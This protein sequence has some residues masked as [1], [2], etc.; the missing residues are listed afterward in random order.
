MK[1]TRTSI[2]CFVAS[3]VLVGCSPKLRADTSD[4]PKAAASTGRHGVVAVEGPTS[5][6]IVDWN[7]EQRADLEEAIRDGVAVMAFDE[8]GLKLLK[9]CR[10]S[11]DYGYLGV[12]T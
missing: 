6:L 5:P 8:S 1:H 3:V 12:T 10:L 9:G 4:Q 2:A 11:G 7:P